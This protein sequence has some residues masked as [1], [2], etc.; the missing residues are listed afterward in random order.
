M[1]ERLLT[2]RCRP[3]RIHG[4]VA[5]AVLALVAG[6]VAAQAPVPAGQAQAAAPALVGPA[7]NVA[8]LARSLKFYTQGLGM[9]VQLQ[10]GRETML[11]FGT[12]QGAMIILLSHAD[13]GRVPAITHGKGFDRLVLRLVD[14][15]AV[16]ARLRAAGATPG[17]MRD[18]SH[19]YRMMLVTDPDGYTLELVER[20]ASQ[21]KPR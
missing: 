18:V 2:I 1:S 20:P 15:P 16:A 5:A 4:M 9:T 6:P 8:D 14:L 21:E 10:K 19:G 13:A 3:S 12:D 11:G 7:L 17:E